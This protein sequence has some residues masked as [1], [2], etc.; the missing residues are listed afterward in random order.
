MAKR[1]GDLEKQAIAILANGGNPALSQDK[2]LANYWAWKTNPSSE[3]HNLPSGSERPKG[4]KT[5]PVYL[6]PFALTLPANILAKV[7]ISQRSDTAVGSPVKTACG[8]EA[9]NVGTDTA[10]ALKGFTPAR[11]YYRTGAATDS[12]NRIS[13]ITKEP[14]K[15]LYAAGDEGFSVPFGRKSTASLAERQAEIKKA[16]PGNPQLVT[17]SPEKYRG[18]T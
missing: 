18:A 15:S 13:R 1:F 17:F 16:L 12:D 9:L 5:N 14:Y 3:A 8:L 6:K 7:T 4:R 2:R 11:V 10:L